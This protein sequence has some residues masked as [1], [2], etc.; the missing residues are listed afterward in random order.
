MGNS[1]IKNH[2]F[3]T[4]FVSSLSIAEIPKCRIDIG[5][6]T[7]LMT[8]KVAISRFPAGMAVGTRVAPLH[9]LGV[10][11]MGIHIRPMRVSY[12]ISILIRGESK[13][14]R[15]HRLIRYKYQKSANWQS[16][17]D[18][19]RGFLREVSGRS[20]SPQRQLPHPRR[21][22]YR[23]RALHVG[24]RNEDQAYSCVRDGR[25]IRLCRT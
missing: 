20:V 22:V 5:K 10:D 15:F 16:L 6:S 21:D 7:A 19:A 1:L 9:H 25:G 2:L 24:P 17:H 14:H 13:E 4:N 3:A 23:V 18:K 11:I 12:K 8:P